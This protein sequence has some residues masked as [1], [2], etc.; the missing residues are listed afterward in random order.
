MVT[1]SSNVPTQTTVG[2]DFRRSGSQMSSSGRYPTPDAR[3]HELDRRLSGL[4][5][6]LR[7]AA[8]PVQADA[9]QAQIDRL[10]ED[11]FRLDGHRSA[12]PL[13]A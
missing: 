4:C 13:P 11:R 1:V 9:C 2:R 8:N 6:Q 12:Q 3:K 7:V 5:W 10:L